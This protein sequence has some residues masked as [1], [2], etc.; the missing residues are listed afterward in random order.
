MLEYFSNPDFVTE[1]WKPTNFRVNR[2]SEWHLVDGIPVPRETIMRPSLKAAKG[3][4]NQ[5]GAEA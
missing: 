1:A 4:A 3:H 5:R 2:F